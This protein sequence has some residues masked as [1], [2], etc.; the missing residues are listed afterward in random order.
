MWGEEGGVGFEEFV[1]EDFGVY[2]VGEDVVGSF[3]YFE[4]VCGY[5]GAIVF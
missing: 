2:E 4:E 5:V 3:G 1:G